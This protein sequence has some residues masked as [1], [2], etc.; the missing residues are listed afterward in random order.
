MRSMVY[1]V[2]Q[3][4]TYSNKNSKINKIKLI[5]GESNYYRTPFV[6]CI[7]WESSKPMIQKTY[8]RNI[9]INSMHESVINWPIAIYPDMI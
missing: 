4:T 2:S 3:G 5:V 8:R 6:Q 7:Y 1:R 9:I